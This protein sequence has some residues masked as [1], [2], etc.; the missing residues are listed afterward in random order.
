MNERG[1]SAQNHA[2]R[3]VGLLFPK[4]KL[5]C[6]SQKPM[7]HILEFILNPH[8]TVMLIQGRKFPFTQ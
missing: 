7:L 2:V 1:Q 8:L 4:V 3:F 5:L 6:S